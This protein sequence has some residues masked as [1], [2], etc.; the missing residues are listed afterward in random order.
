MREIK[1]RVWDKNDKRIFIDPQMID[2]YNKIIGYMQY[3]TQ[4][5][6]NGQGY[7]IKMERTYMREIL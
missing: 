3:Q 1:F 7:M 4:N 6:W 2:F 5:L